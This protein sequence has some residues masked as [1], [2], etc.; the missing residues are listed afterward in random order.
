MSA[1]IVKC[2]VTK[3]ELMVASHV[4]K[5]ERSSQHSRYMSI[6]SY[7]YCLELGKDFSAANTAFSKSQRGLIVTRRIYC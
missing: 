2:D 6:T 4:F 5:K 7:M 3:N 1:N